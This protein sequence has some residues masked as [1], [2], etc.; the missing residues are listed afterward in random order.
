MRESALRSAPLWAAHCRCSFATAVRMRWRAHPVYPPT[1]SGS[2]PCCCTVRMARANRRLCRTVRVWCIR[3]RRAR[4]TCARLT[5]RGLF[6][7]P[8]NPAKNS[9]ARAAC[10]GWLAL[11]LPIGRIG[12]TDRI[13]RTAPPV[14]AGVS[15]P[16]PAV[17][18]IVSVVPLRL[19]RLTCITRFLF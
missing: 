18:S 13:A 2:P 19:R 14:S 3:T 8:T 16:C 12:R 9:V 10:V 6:G 11:I 1:A 5:V 15:Q 4:R 7:T 17:V